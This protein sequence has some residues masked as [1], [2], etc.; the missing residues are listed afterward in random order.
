MIAFLYQ[1]SSIMS[2]AA[3]CLCTSRELQR[4]SDHLLARS[5]AYRSYTGER[6]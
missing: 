5:P 2:A 6:I 4:K 1:K 3:S